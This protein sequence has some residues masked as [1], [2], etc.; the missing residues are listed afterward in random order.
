MDKE[1]Q[2]TGEKENISVYVNHIWDLL[3]SNSL[4]DFRE[5]YEKMKENWSKLF[6]SYFDK[7]LKTDIQC[8]G[9]WLLVKHGIYKP[10]NGVTIN[11]AESFNAVLKR[12]LDRKEVKAQVLIL[13]IYQIDNYYNNEITRGL[14]G[15]G[16]YKFKKRTQTFCY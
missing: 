1:K 12:F 16:N 15:V 11:A 2:K 4:G 8:S 13:S 14:C 7:H 5:K 6:A 10:R 9:K 3:Y